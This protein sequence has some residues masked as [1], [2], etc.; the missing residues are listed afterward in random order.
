LIQITRRRGRQ[1]FNAGIDAKEVPVMTRRPHFTALMATNLSPPLHRRRMLQATVAWAALPA[2][3]PAGAA[4]Y[5]ATIAA[6]QAA[7]ATETSVYLHY[8]AFSQR[9]TQEGYKGIAY[10]FA[11]FSA[12]EQVHAA[13][14]GKI[15]TQLNAELTPLAKPAIRAGATRDNLLLAAEGEM[16]SIDAFYPKLL[17]QIQPEGHEDAINAVKYAWSSE[18]QHRDKIKQ[19]LRW[20]PT[21]FEK[22]A[23]TIDQKT[24][25]YFICQVC[26]STVNAVPA[27][28]CPICGFPST[29]YRG[30]EPPA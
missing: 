4:P 14:F 9:A 25:R 20:A 11:A 13:N 23:R 24:G 15:L 6:M 27:A 10:L 8:N 29:Y 22:V 3:L 12:S 1:A 30:V 16:H 7:R 19:I 17:A 18:Q 2:W 21:F 26:G 28:T 5:P